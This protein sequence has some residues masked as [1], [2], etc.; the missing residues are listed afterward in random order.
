MIKLLLLL[1]PIFSWGSHSTLMGN[2]ITPSNI[3]ALRPIYTGA[4]K[5]AGYFSPQ[6]W[7]VRADGGTRFS[8]NVTSGQCDGLADV[9]YPG[10]GTNQ[11]CAFNDF[12]YT[13]D[14]FS[15][16]VGQGVWVIAGGDT[17]IIRGC[18]ALAGQQNPSNPACRI[19]YDNDSNSGGWCAGIS[20]QGCFMPSIPAGTSGQHTRILG[21]NWAT[22]N[23]GGAT[24]PKLYESNLTQIFGGFS[25]FA[26]LNMSNTS[27]IDIQCLEIDSHNGVC[28]QA[29][30]PSSPRGCNTSP[31]LDDYANSGVFTNLNTCDI[32]FTDVYIHGYDSSGFFGP[33]CGTINLLRVFAGFNEFSGWNFDDSNIYNG[34]NVS[35]A[36]NGSNQITCTYSGPTI[37]Y[38]TMIVLFSGFSGGDA[39]LNGTTATITSGSSGTF[40]G[41]YT[42][43]A[44]TTT[45]TGSFNNEAT[46][47]APGTSFLLTHV[48]FEGNGCYEEYPIVDAFP[49]R[50]CYDTNSS[51]F[52]D[53]IS[54]Q[55]T[56]LDAMMCFD[57]QNLYNTKDC[58]IGPH[59]FINTL[60]IVNS[61]SIGC[62]GS[63]WKWGGNTSANNVT[64]YDNLTV[65]NCVRM[66]QPLPGAPSGYNVNLTGFCRAG[67]NV[68]ASNISPGSTWNI[69]NSTWVVYELTTFFVDCSVIPCTSTINFTN[70]IFLGY[71]NPNVPGYSGQLP[72]LYLLAQPS[73]TGVSSYNVEFGLRNGDCPAGGSGNICLDPLL[74]GEPAQGSVPPE[75]TLDNFDFLL[76]ASS[77]AITNGTASL[78]ADVDFIGLPQTV[79]CTMGAYIF[80]GGL[81]VFSTRPVFRGHH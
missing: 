59:T 18:H 26:T 7:Y 23:T 74:V 29:G 64:F 37:L 43:A 81:P 46:P 16:L 5:A 27:N 78:C 19:G 45:T 58:F 10:S 20:S 41:S 65:G 44:Y 80:N 42:H 31:P 53:S 3:Q 34:N 73:I 67:A 72:A 14:D 1:W 66:S 9:A 50:V 40:T 56:N 51:G 30:S 62:M 35:C 71:T 76:T 47:D 2:E 68:L 36:I 25:L 69:Y 54:G 11:H 49:A 32:N 77:P 39:F 6:T 48:I 15:G 63:N 21:G 38:P 4:S 55:Q 57:C 61:V 75:S 17:V 8:T 79:P 60:T 70:N 33:I 22:C 12:R 52:G 24:N 13:W 28:T